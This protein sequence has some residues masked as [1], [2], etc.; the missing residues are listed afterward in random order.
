MSYCALSMRPCLRYRA[1]LRH[2]GRIPGP[3]NLDDP[4]QQAYSRESS[5]LYNKWVASAWSNFNRREMP[6]PAYSGFSHPEF[7]RWLA[8]IYL[9]NEPNVA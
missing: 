5:A 3:L 4:F 2:S 9:P 7:D 1:W 6:S 8:S